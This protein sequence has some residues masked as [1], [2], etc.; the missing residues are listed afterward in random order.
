MDCFVCSSAPWPMTAS[1]EVM[2]KYLHGDMPE[3]D[4]SELDV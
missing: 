4:E 1:R 2:E 3:I